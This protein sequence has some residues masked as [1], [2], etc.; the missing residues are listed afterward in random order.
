VDGMSLG[1]ING[2]IERVRRESYRW[3]PVRRVYIPKGVVARR[4]SAD[5]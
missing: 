1:K 2:I 5:L 4:P 3:S